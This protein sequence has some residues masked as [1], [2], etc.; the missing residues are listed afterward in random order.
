[1]GGLVIKQEHEVLSGTGAEVGGIIDDQI[2][3]V[4]DR[5]T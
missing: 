5:P 2:F 3:A 4:I 1:M